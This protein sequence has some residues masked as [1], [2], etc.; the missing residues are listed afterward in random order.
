[1]EHRVE[2]GH[3]RARDDEALTPDPRRRRRTQC[4]DVRARDIAHIDRQ[5]GRG[6][7]DTVD[8][9]SGTAAG[10]DGLVEERGCGER[11]DVPLL[12]LCPR[13]KWAIH[14]RWVDCS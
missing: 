12:Y 10:E 14:E 2:P 4:E 3:R 7:W 6:L 9:V 11:P 8:R 1:M 13:R 5:R